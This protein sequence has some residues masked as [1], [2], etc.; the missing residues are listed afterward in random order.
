MA[1]FDSYSSTATADLLP[2][3]MWLVSRARQLAI[4]SPLASAAIDRMTGGIVGDGLTYI[5]S[6]DP[7]ERDI[8]KKWI[9][10]SALKRLDAQHRSTFAQMQDLAVR[11]WLLSGD[12]FFV[13]KHGDISSWRS[14]ESDRVQSPYYLRVKTDSLE[15]YNPDNN[16]RIIDGVELDSD[17]IPV[18]YWILKDY[19]SRP[20]EVTN[21]QIER[22]P[23]TDIDGSP[24]V[25]HLF[26]QKRPDQYRGV[27]LLA[28]SIESL[29]AFTG[30][31]RAT[32]QSAQFQSS[33]WGFITSDNPTMDE[34]EPLLSRDLDQPIPVEEAK[35]DTPATTPT[36]ELSTDPP[37][38]SDLRAQADRMIPSAKRI[39]A[40]QLW[41]LK[42]GEDIKFLQPTNPNNNFQP[43]IK[44]QTELL[45]SSI[46]IPLQ[47]LL[48]SYD[49]TY[50]SARAAVLESN[51][52][53]K[54]LRSFFIEQF[55]KP[56]FGQFVFDVTQDHEV[57]D[58]MSVSSQWQAPTALSLDPTK[59]ADY[60]Q[61]LFDLGLVTRDEIA[62]SL[63]GHKATGTPQTPTKSVEVEEV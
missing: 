38:P 59:E 34:T 54:R 16:N 46:G 50:A 28:E 39:S 58:W 44:A 47:T 37:T 26:A 20:L 40:G 21:E 13:R 18:A 57:A 51:R 15:C 3:R 10:A 35:P 19:I 25:L 27:P 5:V 60:W 9:V 55:I 61:K 48:C 45:A 43:Y 33:V 12:I 52:Q 1:G 42:S 56:I 6:E 8:A 30:Y 24:L 31:L 36:F 2:T 17:S 41:N 11:N 49:T 22:I 53:F 32:E 62:L 4:S 63:L 29:H 14:I 23:A 7:F